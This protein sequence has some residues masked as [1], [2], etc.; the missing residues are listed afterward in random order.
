MFDLVLQLLRR[1]DLRNVNLVNRHWHNEARVAVT[2]WKPYP[3]SLDQYHKVS[4]LFPNITEVNFERCREGLTDALLEASLPS[5]RGLKDLTALNLAG[6]NGVSNKGIAAVADILPHLK[7]LSLRAWSADGLRCCDG[8]WYESGMTVGASEARVLGTFSQLVHLDLSWNP[9]DDDVLQVLCSLTNLTGLQVKECGAITD[10]GMQHIACLPQLAFLNLSNTR[11]SDEGLMLLGGLR[12]E[13]LC[14]SKCSQIS[15][16]G[17][18]WVKRISTIRQLDVSLCDGVTATGVEQ[19]RELPCL[20]VLHMSGCRSIA[21]QD[22]KVLRELKC[23]EVLNLRDSVWVTDE[24]LHALSGCTAL[25]ALNLRNCGKVTDKGLRSLARVTTLG[26]L[27]LR[28]CERTTDDSLR[29]LATIVSL[30]DLDLSYC[31]EITDVG[32]AAISSLPRLRRLVLNWCRLISTEGLLAL[33]HRKHTLK[34]LSIKGCHL[35]STTSLVSIT[36]NLCALEEI[37]YEL[38]QCT[39][40]QVTACGVTELPKLSRIDSLGCF[41]EVC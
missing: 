7:S 31:G 6:C 2:R 30:E 24:T 15:D 38:C 28:G 41:Q 16:D 8:S 4:G 19:L 17:L 14:L 33:Q 29:V 34:Q 25:R 1:L 5:L 21:P 18:F 35:L 20:R 9:V 23:L 37:D 22:V 36:S 39:V 13:S 27:N 12:L 10:V 26:S 32:V 3:S 40:Q 11:V